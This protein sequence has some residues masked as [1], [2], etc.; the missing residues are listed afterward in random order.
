M[1]QTKTPEA[2]EATTLDNPLA[3]P[4]TVSLVNAVGK[5]ASVLGRS[6]ASMQNESLRFMNQRLEDNMKAASEIGTCR[7]LPELLAFQ[8]KWFATMTRAYAEEWHR[9]NVL[10]TD[11]VRGDGEAVDADQASRSGR[12]REDQASPTGRFRQ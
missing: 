12:E 6:V 9:Y 1:K 7:S 2:R 5:G 10:L 3:P 4:F 11:I 8:Q